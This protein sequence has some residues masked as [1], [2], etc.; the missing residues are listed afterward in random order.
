MPMKRY[1]RKFIMLPIIPR[2]E[3]PSYWYPQIVPMGA[4]RFVTNEIIAK[5]KHIA[6]MAIRRPFPEVFEAVVEFA[7]V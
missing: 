5:R 6:I 3:L 7:I 4:A 2:T 1:A